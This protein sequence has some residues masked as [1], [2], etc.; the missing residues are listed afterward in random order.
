MAVVIRWCT[1]LAW[2]A[3]LGRC[4]AVQ[5]VRGGVQRVATHRGGRRGQ[6]LG[7]LNLITPRADDVEAA[8]VAERRLQVVAPQ[9]FARCIW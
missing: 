3:V 6:L 2:P 4:K 8:L 1:Q 7:R 5:A 9:Q